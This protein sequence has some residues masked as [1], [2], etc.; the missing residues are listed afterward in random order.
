MLNNTELDYDDNNVYR[1][2][3]VLTSVYTKPWDPIDP[4]RV[5]EICESCSDAV[6][7][8][9]AVSRNLI[10]PVVLGL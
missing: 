4:E 5:V 3:T 1:R 7:Y 10:V 2:S 9:N 8:R 6:S